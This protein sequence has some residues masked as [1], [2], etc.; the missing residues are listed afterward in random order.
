MNIS[1]DV[2]LIFQEDSKDKFELYNKVIDY[3]ENTVQKT[4]VREN[5]IFYNHVVALLYSINNAGWEERHSQQIEY[6]WKI[7]REVIEKLEDYFKDDI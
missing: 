4:V 6:L 1:K 3:I 7:Q 5:E 2:F